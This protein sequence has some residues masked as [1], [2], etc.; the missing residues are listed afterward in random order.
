VA[1][2]RVVVQRARRVAEAE[3]GAPRAAQALQRERPARLLPAFSLDPPVAR[4]RPMAKPPLPAGKSKQPVP[5]N[6]PY[7]THFHSPWNFFTAVISINGPRLGSLRFQMND[8]VFVI[9]HERMAILAM[10]HEKPQK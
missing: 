10:R 7:Q 8:R 4:R 3:Q 1:A 2:R 6:L 5:R 9:G